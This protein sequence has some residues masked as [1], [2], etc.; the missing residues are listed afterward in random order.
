[1]TRPAALIPTYQNGRTIA[2]VV[3]RTCR[4]IADVLVVDDGSTDSA[5]E[6]LAAFAGRVNVHRHPK[7]LGKGRALR[8]GFARLGASGF[9]HAIAL[10]GDGQH[11]PEDI[12]RFLLALEEQPGAILIGQ[13]DMAA[14][15]APRRSRFGLWFSNSS[16]R[17]LSGAKLADSQ[18]GFRVYP[19]EP[20]ARL[21]LRGERYDLELEVLIKA[22]R[23]GIPLVPVPIRVTYSPP[24]GRVS[25]FRPVRDFLQIAVR[26][27]RVLVR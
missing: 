25:H 4:E 15:A 19:L 27:A 5:S 11:Y 20:I 10:D 23:A 14:S 16:L 22:A 12:P 18:C 3:Q 26:V 8:E 13:R 2:D 9:S 17:W 6:A 7:N 21:D 24:G 1:M